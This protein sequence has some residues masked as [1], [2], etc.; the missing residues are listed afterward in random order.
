MT[1]RFASPLM[2]LVLASGQALGGEVHDAVNAGRL[3]QVKRLIASNP[4]LVNEEEVHGWTPLFLAAATGYTAMVEVLLNSGARI[5]AKDNDGDTALHEAAANARR[6]VVE[7]LLARGA[8]VN[9]A[10]NSGMTPLHR[11]ARDG[12]MSDHKAVIDVLLANKANAS[13]RDKAGRTPLEVAI[14]EGRKEMASHL[15]SKTTQR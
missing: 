3:E 8:N 7:L 13:A 6:P 4:R 15:R 11:V 1:R 5:D 12:H 2:V 14:K 10:N 9:A